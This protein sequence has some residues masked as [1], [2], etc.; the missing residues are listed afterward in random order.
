[1]KLAGIIK[2]LAEYRK[3]TE[4]ALAQMD[5]LYAERMKRLTEQ[6]GRVGSSEAVTHSGNRRPLVD[7][8]AGINKAIE[9]LEKTNAFGTDT[10]FKVF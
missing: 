1:M 10:D 9:Q 4:V 5:K 3:Q 6:H 7:R 8:I 2:G